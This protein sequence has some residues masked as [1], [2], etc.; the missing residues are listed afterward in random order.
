MNRVIV[1][2]GAV[3][4][5]TAV[6]LGAFGAHALRDVLSPQQA[7]WW[8]TGV[9]YQMCHALALL[10]VAALP[11]RRAGL[12][13]GCLGAGAVIFSATLYLMA[14]GGPRWLGAVTPVGGALMIVGWGVLAWGALRV[15][16][17]P[18]TSDSPTP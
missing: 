14:L 1:A 13:A 11:L 12:A 18:G 4:G 6:M 7:G 3:L 5:A 9:Q 17:E 10:L 15:R 2:A 8:E 16:A